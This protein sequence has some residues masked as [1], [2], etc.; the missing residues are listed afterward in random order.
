MMGSWKYGNPRKRYHLIILF[1]DEIPIDGFRKNGLEVGIRI[2]FPYFW[3]GQA[4]GI[5][6]FEAGHEL[7]TT[8][9]HALPV[10]FR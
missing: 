5:N 4:L 1:S 3:P 6:I 9:V 2:W 10:L 7:D 8:D